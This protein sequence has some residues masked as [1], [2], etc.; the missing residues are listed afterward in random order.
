MHCNMNVNV[1][2]IT[3]VQVTAQTYILSA[4]FHH[5]GHLLGS[6][7]LLNIPNTKILLDLSGSI[8]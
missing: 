1:M 4:T 7:G 3:T 8:I 5:L 2:N 6:G